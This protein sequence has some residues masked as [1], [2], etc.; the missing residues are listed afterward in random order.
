[1]KYLNTLAK[2]GMV[3]AF[4][5]L[6]TNFAWAQRTVKGKVT[7]A[8]TGEGLIGATVTVVGTTRG[9]TT[10]ID[11]NYSVDV[12]AGSTQ[13]RFAYTGYTEQVI[14]LTASNVVSVALKPGTVLDE[15]VVIGYGAVRKVD[16]TGAVA[17]VT[18]KNFN[19]N[20][21]APEQL[22][23]GRAAGVVVTNSSGEPGAGI[24]IRIRGNSSVRAGNNPL[25]VVD[26]VPLSGD[27]TSGSS[28]V[29]GLGSQASRNPLNF[30]NPSDIASIDILKDAS[31]TAIYGSRGANGVVII[32]TKSGQGGK[33]KLEYGYTLGMSKLAKK[34]DVLNA[35]EFLPSRHKLTGIE[36]V[37]LHEQACQEIRRTQCQ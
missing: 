17:S 10:D 13:L 21:V 14:D 33:G 3:M 25:F 36:Y 23:Q 1:M 37:V 15:V 5:L 24:N 27:E 6:L 22:I 8:E 4:L 7:D 16:A 28:N 2:G 31:A 29:Q 32:T 34:Y 12:P 19:R 26:G 11:G 20:A 9:G 30:L 18:E 35:S